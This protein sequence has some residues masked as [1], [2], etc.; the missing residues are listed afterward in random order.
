M[1][2][3]LGIASGLPAPL[4]FGNLSIWLRELGVSRTEIGLLAFIATPY[5]LNFLWAP[6]LDRTPPPFFRRLGQRRGWALSLQC[7]LLCT[8]ALWATRHP[9]EGLLAFAAMALLIATL[10]ATQDIAIDAW[11]VDAIERERQGQAAAFATIGWH[12]GGTLLGGAGGLLIADALGWQAAW[13]FTGC[14]LVLGMGGVLLAHEPRPHAA[15]S[16]DESGAPSLMRVLRGMVRAVAL[17]LGELLKRRGVVLLLVF[18]LVFRLGDAM[19]GRMAHV[20]YVDLGFQRAEIAEISKV[21]GLWANL[22]GVVVGGMLTRWL[23]LTR[24]L[25][26]SGFATAVTNLCYMWMATAGHERGPFILA[27]VADSFTTGLVTVAFVGFLSALCAREHAA[28]HYALLASLGNLGRLWF[29]ASAGWVVDSLDGDW[30]T[31]FLWTAGVALL[32]LPLLVWL[33]RRS[34]SLMPR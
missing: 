19:L 24:A 1:V 22:A 26:V 7:V 17:P 31:F 30:A 14:A 27:V 3:L 2:L 9:S 13:F 8:I 18:I 20:F 5:A 11:R 10:S 25:F 23:G 21:Y 34:P 16:A 6:L 15:R 32:G 4:I 33:Q 29:A 12:V 28:T